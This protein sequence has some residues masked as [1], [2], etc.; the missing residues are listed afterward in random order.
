MFSSHHWDVAVCTGHVRIGITIQGR[1]LPPIPSMHNSIDSLMT[2]GHCHLWTI[3]FVYAAPTHYKVRPS[4]HLRE[5]I[6]SLPSSLPSSV[7]WSSLQT[8]RTNH[9]CPHAPLH[10]TEEQWT[11]GEM[12]WKTLCMI[13]A[14]KL[15]SSTK[16]DIIQRLDKRCM[17]N[18]YSYSGAPVMFKS[19]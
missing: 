19:S 18:S 14:T 1:A 3:P 10:A 11:E 6:L 17:W 15:M 2:I 9:H 13:L 8:H 16:N 4:T 12:G 5:M 7:A